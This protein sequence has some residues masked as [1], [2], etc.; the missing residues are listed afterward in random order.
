[1]KFPNERF[2]GGDLQERGSKNVIDAY[3]GWSGLPQKN[4]PIIFH[5]MSGKDEREASSPS[6]FNND[7]ILQVKAYIA[8]LRGDRRVRCSSC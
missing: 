7:E 1:M 8:Q 3:V 6:F 5:G 4:F 2:Y